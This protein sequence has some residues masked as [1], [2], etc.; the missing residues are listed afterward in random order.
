[1]FDWE[2]VRG[3]SEN[4]EREMGNRVKDIALAFALGAPELVTIALYTISV[5]ALT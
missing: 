3:K 4:R 1:L 2:E 5:E